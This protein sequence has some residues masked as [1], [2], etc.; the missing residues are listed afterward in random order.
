MSQLGHW[1]LNPKTEEV[2][3]SEEL[4]NIFNLS[5]D[6]ASLDAFAQ[7]V[8]PEDREKDLYLIKRGI[9]EGLPW[10][11]KHRLLLR[12]GTEKTVNTIGEVIK[13]EQGRIIELIGTVQDITTQAITEKVLRESEIQITRQLHTKHYFDG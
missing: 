6:Q 4:F 10:R 8:H 1:R 3:G 5:K 7:V 12:D 2:S 9:N 13:D 11:L